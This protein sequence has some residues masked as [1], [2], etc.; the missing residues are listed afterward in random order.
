M[1]QEL[2]LRELFTRSPDNKLVYKGLNKPDYKPTILD[3]YSY[4]QST[5]EGDDDDDKA[6]KI[7][8]LQ[9]ISNDFQKYVK[10]NEAQIL[11]KIKDISSIKET[12]ITDDDL[13]MFKLL[14]NGLKEMDEKDGNRM[15]ITLAENPD[16]LE[17]FVQKQK[18]DVDKSGVTGVGEPG[19]TDV[20]K[21][22]VTDVDKPGVTDVNKRRHWRGGKQKGGVGN[23]F[24]KLKSALSLNEYW[25]KPWDS[26]TIYTFFNNNYTDKINKV[27]RKIARF[28]DVEYFHESLDA[29]IRH[30]EPKYLQKHH[31]PDI[32]RD[33]IR[34]IYHICKHSLQVAYVVTV[35]FAAMIHALLMGTTIATIAIAYWTPVV[36]LSLME[37]AI[38]P[39]LYAVDLTAS[40]I[41]SLFRTTGSVAVA[42]S[43]NNDIGAPAGG[44]KKTRNNK[45]K[46]KKN[47]KRK[48]RNTNRR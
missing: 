29:Y 38:K 27:L 30:K 42:D 37:L 31:D 6:F 45:K 39:A 40:T 4:A 14:L 3:F 5:D 25:K 23:I 16:F 33:F 34:L 13:A 19:V 10:L 11:Q 44:S 22:G 26:S 36:A 48:Q 32:I 15:S 28:A 7:Q 41:A 47:K 9:E 2:K 18:K 12:D 35:P 46:T 43:N 1:P 21:S 24:D 8:I 17:K 20:D